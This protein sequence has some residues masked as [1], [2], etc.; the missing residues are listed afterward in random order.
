MEN[1]NPQKSSSNEYFEKINASVVAWLI[2]LTF[3]GG[4]LSLYYAQIRYLPDIEWSSSLVFL[5]LAT[6]VGGAF[7][8]ALGLSLFIPGYLWSE[9]LLFD[10]RLKYVFCFHPQTGEVCLRTVGK[11]IGVPFGIVLL[12]NHL[13]LLVFPCLLS[14]DSFRGTKL[15]WLYAIVSIVLLVV[16]SIVMTGVFRDLQSSARIQPASPSPG[17]PDEEK[18]RLFK[19]VC[20]FGL[21]IIVSQISMM[22]IHLMSNRPTGMPF[23]ITTVFCALGVIVSNHVVAIHFRRSR[24]HAILTSVV[25]ASLLM[26]I[27]DRNESLSSQVV[28]FFGAGVKSQQVDLVLNDDGS[29]MIGSLNLGD[30]CPKQ[31]TPNPINEGTDPNI[32]AGRVCQVRILSRLGS[33]FYLEHEGRKFTL[34]KIFVVSRI[35]SQKQNPVD[36]NQCYCI[37]N[38]LC[39]TDLN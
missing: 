17:P 31:G 30:T 19:Y 18:R 28:A 12:L 20:W 25:I 2:F 13:A 9:F 37:F 14:C 27:A 4:I 15:L 23:L 39:K 32:P 29:K 5:A 10:E 33:E 38:C 22:L 7:A 11:Y 34:P 35:T 21:S 16:I 36:T 6:F 24:L 1:V 8:L 26:F 3:G